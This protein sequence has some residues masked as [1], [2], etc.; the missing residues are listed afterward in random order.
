MVDVDPREVPGL[1][2]AREANAVV[3]HRSPRSAV[4]AWKVFE[5][6]LHGNAGTGAA[7]GRQ[8]PVPA[9]RGPSI[10]WFRA[11]SPHTSV[12]FAPLRRFASTESLRQHSIVRQPVL[13][14][15]DQRKRLWRAS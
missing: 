1:N 15:A 12:R 6:Q 10:L 11:S 4:P 13:P 5:G 2:I 7:Q 9:R 8:G 14:H 3:G